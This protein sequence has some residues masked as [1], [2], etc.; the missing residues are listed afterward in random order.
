MK[1][2]FDGTEDFNT[3]YDARPNKCLSEA[4]EVSVVGCRCVYVNN[5]RICGG[6]PYF[7]ENLPSHEFSTTLG[8]V[9]SAFSEKQILDAL[10]E[11]KEQSE[12]LAAYR[13]ARDARQSE[14][15]HDA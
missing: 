14:H 13:A 6:K 3:I 1:H 15:S 8:D 2:N 12:Y 7:S 5:Y 9:L 11:R 4:I 10:A